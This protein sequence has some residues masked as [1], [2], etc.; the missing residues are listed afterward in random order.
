MTTDEDAAS[1]GGQAEVYRR[2]LVRQ[3]QAYEGM[4]KILKTEV[5][6]LQGQLQ[7]AYKRIQELAS[8]NAELKKKE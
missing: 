2:K 8:E 1:L 4:V 3:D 7:R 5:H 6:T